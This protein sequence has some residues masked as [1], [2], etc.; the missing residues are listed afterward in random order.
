MS[1][2]FKP[3]K[4]AVEQQQSP[5]D[6]AAK[7]LALIGYKRTGAFASAPDMAN[8]GY[9]SSYLQSMPADQ[10]GAANGG[11]LQFGYGNG[12]LELLLRSA[13][14]V[15]RGKRLDR[16]WNFA[17]SDD[18]LS[19]GLQL[20]RKFTTSGFTLGCSQ[21]S[22]QQVLNQDK[23]D[24]DKAK[25]A[26]ILEQAK[27][28]DTLRKLMLEWNFY[29]IAKDLA[30][31]WYALDS[32]ILYWRVQPEA[33][34]L[35]LSET[36]EGDI[37]IN[38]N[39]D[40]VSPVN[41]TIPGICQVGVLNPK[42]C[43]WVNDSGQNILLYR[44]PQK[45]ILRIRAIAR[46]RTQEEKT[47]AIRKLVMTGFSIQWIKQVL[48]GSNY[49]TLD[50][51]DGHNWLIRTNGPPLEGLRCPT[52]YTIFLYL[53]MRR[54]LRDG[55]FSTAYMMKHF[56]QHVTLGESIDSG[57]MAGSQNNWPTQPEIEAMHGI[58][59][60]AVKCARLITNHTVKV[61][62]VFPPE[63]MFK[64][65]KYAKAEDAIMHWL[66]MP[67]VLLKGEGGTNSSGYIGVRRTVSDI[68][69][70]REEINQIFQLFFDHPSVREAMAQTLPESYHINAL[71][72]EN[73][74]KEP[75]Q[76]L[77]EIEFFYDHHVI[78]PETALAETNRD[79]NRIR[80]DKQRDMSLNEQTDIYE[81]VSVAPPIGMGKA[82]D[83]GRPPNAGTTQNE[84]TRTQPG[85]LS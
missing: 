73:V 76:L 35:G 83:G 39:E 22:E 32:M 31:Q 71:F 55:D 16:A 23:L 84:E 29:G 17:E 36:A 58:M 27:L 51:A 28:K 60:E 13:L 38:E 81:P 40:G 34:K 6:P 49:V 72:N 3:R 12:D 56:I 79:P 41:S 21:S 26:M 77:K 14:P 2:P 67:V 20:K 43:E 74:L 70:C 61:S 10:N 59:K 5:E 15:E 65:G 53:E 47:A 1:L 63:D 82:T 50:P 57:P 62:Y 80:M 85:T 9:S 42:D 44:L 4:P 24:D 45:I 33:E 52:M 30:T 19:G 11:A 54:C 48:K 7:A 8:S 75:A 64:T 18:F 68:A 46:L 69:D 37:V 66:G 25:K 78:G